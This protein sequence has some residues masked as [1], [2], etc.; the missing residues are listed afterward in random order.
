MGSWKMAGWNVPDSVPSTLKGNGTHELLR[1]I[2]VAM[3]SRL[4]DEMKTEML[5]QFKD[6]MGWVE[7][8]LQE[9]EW[10]KQI[11]KIMPTHLFVRPKGVL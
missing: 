2:F 8:I 11:S 3:Y 10:M 1:K 4:S 5:T 7:G 9:N 6:E